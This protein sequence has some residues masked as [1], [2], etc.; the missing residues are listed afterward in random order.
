M[1]ARQ[2]TALGASIQQKETTDNQSLLASASTVSRLFSEASNWVAPVLA[3]TLTATAVYTTVQLSKP[4]W[5]I[6]LTNPDQISMPAQEF[7]ISMPKN[8]NTVK[9]EDGIDYYQCGTIAL[10]DLNVPLSPQAKKTLAEGVA[11]KLS[12]IQEELKD[13]SIPVKVTLEPPCS[14]SQ[15]ANKQECD[16]LKV[17]GKLIADPDIQPALNNN[18]NA[19]SELMKKLEELI[20]GQD[21]NGNPTGLQINPERLKSVLLKTQELK[22]NDTDKKDL[23]KMI[24]LLTGSSP[25]SLLKDTNKKLDSID[26][27]LAEGFSDLGGDAAQGE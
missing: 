20:A 23:E 9:G 12:G 22:I 18:S 4:E 6:P 2:M 16:D 8:C 15:G 3:S 26:S 13:V 11:V 19:Q 17:F 1:P 7:K 14:Q 24:E 5:G 10:K 27:S 25:T 21:E